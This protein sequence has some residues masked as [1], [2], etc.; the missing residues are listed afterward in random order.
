MANKEHPHIRVILQLEEARIGDQNRLESIKESLRTGQELPESDKMYIAEQAAQ[1]QKAIEHQMLSDWAMDFVQKIREKEKETN[2]YRID[3]EFLEQASTELKQAID[4]EKKV[5]WTLDLISQL[6]E[7]QI[8]DTEKLD[9]IDT[10]LRSGKRVEEDDKQYLKAKDLHL[11]QLTDCKT[12]ITLTQDAARKLQEHE[13]TH[14]KKLEA[15]IHIIE[16]GNLVSK[17]DQR[18]LNARYEKLQ[19]SLDKQNR[20]EWTISTIQKLEEFGVGNYEKL[21]EI[22]QLLE[23]DIPVPESDA[24]YLREEYKLLRLILKHKKKIDQTID[25]IQ[26]LQEMEIGHCERLSAIKRLLDKGTLVPES[27]ISYLKDK[28]KI[29]MIVKRSQGHTTESQAEEVDYNPILNELNLAT[30]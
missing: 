10:L 21:D 7:A 1:L 19:S 6:R 16:N 3:R 27:E 23:D 20:I 12:K 24:K 30:S 25:L 2:S 22:R 4:S 9:R 29:L 28:C 13:M 18:Y 11:R 14:S 5:N 8:G 15:I 26:E 17:R